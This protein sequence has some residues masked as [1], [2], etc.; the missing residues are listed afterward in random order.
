[1]GM[2]RGHQASHDFWGLQNCSRSTYIP[3]YAAATP[4]H[5]LKACPH[6]R[7]KVRQF[8]AENSRIRR[9]SPLSRRFL[10][11]SH[12]SAKVALFCDGVDRAL[13]RIASGQY[14]LPILQLH[15]PQCRLRSVSIATVCHTLIYVL[16]L[17]SRCRTAGTWLGISSTRKFYFCRRVAPGNGAR[18]AIPLIPLTVVSQQI[19][20]ILA[21]QP[22]A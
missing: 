9:L 6:C 22:Q 17:L 19:M 12:F 18:R 2:I 8:V 10:R 4:S 14:N 16:N 15:P 7:R 21:E 1:M 13:H 11:Q 20:E 5:S 3:R